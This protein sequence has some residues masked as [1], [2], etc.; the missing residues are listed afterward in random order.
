MNKKKLSVL[1]SLIVIFCIIM[2]VVDAF[3]MADYAVKSVIKFV[4]FLVLP[5]LY[6]LYDKTID[7]KSIFKMNKKGIITAV[8][9]GVAVYVVIL[10]AYIIFKDVFDF[11]MITSALTKNIGVSKD[12]F[13]YVS[14]YISFVNALLE[15]FFFRGFAFLTLKRMS[16][17]S[18]AYI[19]S[20]AVFS[21]YHVAMMIGWFS[22]WLFLLVLIGLFIGGLIFNFLNDRTGN[23]YT[24]YLVHMFANFAINTIGFILFGI[25]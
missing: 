15:E 6:S 18:F 7:L 5:V 11:S 14:I 20:A 16:S 19:F 17:A 2:A 1:I 9:L 3:L 22:I 13:V 12:N 21:I 25:I 10:G 4:L 8:V 23:I 24:S